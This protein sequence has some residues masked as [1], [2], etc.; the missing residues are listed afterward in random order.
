MLT[1]V[2]GI[3]G[4]KLVDYKR[5]INLLGPQIDKMDHLEGKISTILPSFSHYFLSF[6]RFIES[7][8]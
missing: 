1:T 5:G 7:Q 3:E 6:E 8:V 4:G 2:R